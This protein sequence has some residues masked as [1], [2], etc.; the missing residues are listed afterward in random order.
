M[1]ILEIQFATPEYDETVQLRDKILRK[2]LGLTFSEAQLAEEFADFHLAAYT[3]EWVLRGCLVLT[4]TDDKTLKM[5]QVAVDE[6]VQKQGVGQQLVAASESFGRARG[7]ETM[8]LNAR[9]TA[10][11]FYKKLN[12]DIVGER[13][14]EVGI[15]HFKM[16]KKL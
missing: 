1:T 2:P 13:F 9:E 10:V 8:V 4:P 7:F 5:R 11:P 14:E 3:D 16:M 6:R 15:P 12:Y